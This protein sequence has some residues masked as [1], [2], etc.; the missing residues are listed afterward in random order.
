MCACI[1]CTSSKNAVPLEAVDQLMLVLLS[2][3][4]FGP[5]DAASSDIRLLTSRYHAQITILNVYWPNKSVIMSSYTLD[6]LFC[7]R[8]TQSHQR[9]ASSGPSKIGGPMF[10]SRDTEA[11]SVHDNALEPSSS[12]LEVVLVHKLSTL[13]NYM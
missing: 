1:S 5:E 3:V 13:I 10:R 4:L 6:F 7:Y 2:N 9:R 8:E 11:N 12:D